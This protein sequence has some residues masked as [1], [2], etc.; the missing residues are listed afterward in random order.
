MPLTH[1]DEL[2]S[3]AKKVK[4][5]AV[6]SVLRP[7]C[8]ASAGAATEAAQDTARANSINNNRG[9]VCGYLTP[10]AQQL[11]KKRAARDRQDRTREM[12]SLAVLAGAL[13]LRLGS[14]APPRAPRGAVSN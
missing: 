12:L 5:W 1:T 9:C 8:C 2:R 7:F 3:N 10:A 14:A 11:C 13:L 4:F 6:A